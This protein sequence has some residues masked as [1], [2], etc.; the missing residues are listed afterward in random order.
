MSFCSRSVDQTSYWKSTRRTWT[1]YRKTLTVH[2]A[3][4]CR[5]GNNGT[6][7]FPHPVH[8]SACHLWSPWHR[9]VCTSAPARS[10]PWAEPPLLLVSLRNWPRA[11]EKQQNTQMLNYLCPTALS[12]LSCFVYPKISIKKPV[13]I[14]TYKCVLKSK[15]GSFWLNFAIY[16]M[17]W[18]RSVCFYSMYS[19]TWWVRNR[20]T[21]PMG[22]V[23]EGHRGLYER[24][25]LNIRPGNSYNRAC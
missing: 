18:T 14:D 3:F 11:V 6:N 15:W 5:F 21:H 10:L 8:R 19:L 4:S 7:R 24:C 22:T 12:S 25:Y 13:G 16:T 9:Q 2:F 23:A 1:T 17:N 20:C